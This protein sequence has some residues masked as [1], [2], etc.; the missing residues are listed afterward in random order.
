M[1]VVVLVVVIVVVV[2][3]VL[4]GM[5]TRPGVDKAEAGQC[6]EARADYNK[7]EFKLLAHMSEDGEQ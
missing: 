3:L 1:V 2:I 7:A 5:I 6:I 4:S